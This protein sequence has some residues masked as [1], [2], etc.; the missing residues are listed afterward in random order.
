MAWDDRLLQEQKEAAS[1]IGSHARLLAGP[2]TGKTLTLTQR[3]NFLINECGINPKEILVISFTRATVND[4]QQHIAKILDPDRIPEI[5]TLHSFSLSAL[6]RHQNNLES[7]PQPLRIAGDWEENN[8]VLPDIKKLLGLRNISEV[9]KLLARL[10]SDWQS[11]AAEKDDW[12]DRFPNPKFI[13]EWLKHRT[14]Y[15]YTLRSEL[16]YQLKRCLEQRS[17]LAIGDGIKYILVDE[18]QDLNLCDLAVIKQISKYGAEVFVAGDDDQ[19]IYGFRLAH[20]NGI[21][22]FP[23]EYSGTKELELTICKRCPK[24]ILDLGLFVARQDANRI[25]KTL[26]FDAEKGEGIVKC[27]YFKDSDKEAK[28][29]AEICNHLISK[30]LFKPSDILILLHTD[31]LERYSKP[32]KMELD[33]FAIPYTTGHSDQLEDTDLRIL[34][35]FFRLVKNRKDSLSWRILLSFWCRGIGDKYIEKLYNY[36]FENGYSFAETVETIRSNSNLNDCNFPKIVLTSI[37]NIYSKLE[38]LNSINLFI[39]FGESD[40]LLEMILAILPEIIESQEE[41]QNLKDLVSELIL[42]NDMKSICDLIALVSDNV[43]DPDN[44][45]EEDKVNIMSMHKAKGLGAEVVIIIAAEDEGIPG[46]AVGEKLNEKLRLLY[47]SITRAKNI[48]FI[49]YCAK[50]SGSQSYSGRSGGNPNRRLTRFL[51]HSNVKPEYG[52]NFI[53]NLQRGTF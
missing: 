52:K 41:L 21:R 33:N 35:S 27:L 4:L 45:K 20:P 1:H 44:V 24:R 28:G 39:E 31:S 18:Y 42:D 22:M 5:S 26:T 30:K 25:D 38:F 23:D 12:E 16:V 47:V 15:G 8:I 10:S 49:T 14:I 32:I 3:V 2:G 37:D 40:N 51:S 7:F 53:M 43:G 36:A 9:K 29:V 46:Q 13:G 11:L 6:L 19:S 50:R 17:D 34:V 48:L